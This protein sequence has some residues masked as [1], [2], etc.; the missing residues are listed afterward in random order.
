MDCTN[1]GKPV[2]EDVQFCPHCGQVRGSPSIQDVPVD[3]LDFH[4]LGWVADA[5]RIS[6]MVGVSPAGSMR[7]PVEVQVDVAKIR[8]HDS[9]IKNVVEHGKNLGKAILPPAVLVLLARSLD[10]LGIEQGLRLHCAS[11]TN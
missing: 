1:C 2:P 11:T 4:L 8:E 7:R 5:N 9:D 6:V 10:N 3:Y